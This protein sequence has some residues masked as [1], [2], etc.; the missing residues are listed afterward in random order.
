MLC[1]CIF[2]RCSADGT[3]MVRHVERRVEY[4]A[5]VTNTRGCTQSCIANGYTDGLHQWHLMFGAEHYIIH[6]Q[7][8]QLQLVGPQPY[9]LSTRQRLRLPIEATRSPP[10]GQDET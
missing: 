10:P 8:V 9:P 7:V 3:D 1:R 2:I 5:K 6:H 4:N